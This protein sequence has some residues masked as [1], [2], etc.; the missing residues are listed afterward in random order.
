M[1]AK[2][3][4]KKTTLEYAKEV[5]SNS[6]GEYR[7]ESSYVNAN[8]KVKFKHLACGHFFWMKPNSFNNG[9]RCSNRLCKKQRQ[10]RSAN[11]RSYNRLVEYSNQQKDHYILLTKFSLYRGNESLIRLYCKRC[12]RYFSITPHSFLNGRG[13]CKCGNISRRLKKMKD[14]NQFYNEVYN[15]LGFDYTLESKYQ[16]E[17]KLIKIKHSCGYSWWARPESLLAG[18]QCKKCFPKR[19]ILRGA[20]ISLLSKYQCVPVN[21]LGKEIYYSYDKIYIQ[22]Q[23]GYKFW[24]KVNR[25]RNPRSKYGI[26]KKC[27]RKKL[28]KDLQ[29]SETEFL[30]RF[31]KL[32]F[33][34]EYLIIGSYQG[35]FIPIRIYH[36][37]C[38][39]Y[40]DVTPQSLL[41]GRECKWCRNH[42]K[43]VGE[44][45]ICSWLDYMNVNYEYPKKFN[46]L[47]DRGL[48]HYD[49][50]LPEYNIL[51]EVQGIQHYGAIKYFGGEEQF[52]L[53]QKHDQMKRK[54]AK[55]HGYRLIEIPTNK[56]SIKD[57]IHNVAKG[58]IRA[59]GRNSM[60]QSIEQGINNNTDN[61]QQAEAV[62]QVINSAIERIVSQY[63]SKGGE[64]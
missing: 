53:Q 26:C 19:G 5:I 49:F 12:D 41:R 24:Q 22:H 61:Q 17:N 16:G 13:C 50:Y 18:Q 56:E 33:S 42:R 21:H 46:D 47:S 62:A 14:P 58:L 48:L 57:T 9:Q 44:R 55:K 15:K 8:V 35:M 63:N 38:H 51:I 20:L 1:V 23:C 37:L 28:G 11:L 30:R 10:R 27:N 60:E 39:H 7:L 36:K 3:Y 43:S 64:Y 52:K 32:P 25:I 29:L 40:D 59:F 4:G 54:Y 34:K 45:L 2:S 31:N 6:N